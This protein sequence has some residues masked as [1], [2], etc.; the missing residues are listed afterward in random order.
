MRV[1]F[2]VCGLL[3]M[4][5]IVYGN[6]FQNGF[7]FD[8]SHTVIDNPYIR[9]LHNLS[10]FFKDARTFSTLPS[11]RT[12]RP[13][14]S[15]SLAIDYALGRG[16]NPAYFHASTFFWF[17]LQLALMFVLFLKIGDASIQDPGNHWIALFA[18]ALYGLH[19]A[20]AETMNYV[21]QRADLYS[22][23]GVIAALVC[24]I[25]A[26]RLRKFGLYLLPFVAALLSKP[27]AMVFPAI[28][29]VY[30]WLFEEEKAAP[31]LVRCVPAIAVAAGIAGFMA[32][33]TP[34][35]FNAGS[36]SAYAYRLTQPLVA[37]RY[38]R[39]FFIPDHLTADS[40][41]APVSSIVQDEAWLGF[42]FVIAVFIAAIWTSRKREW[43][44]VAFG[45]WWFL[46]AL[47]PTAVFPLAE[48]END[49]RM[50]FPFVGLTFA[51]SCAAGRWIIRRAPHGWFRAATAAAG[52]VVLS[53]CAWGTRQRNDVWHTDESLWYD[54]TVK[55]PKNGR[56]LMNY[57]LTQMEKGDY[58][59]ARDYFN[60]ALPYTPNYYLLYVNLGIVNGA[61]HDDIAAEQHFNRAIQLAPNQAEPRYFFAR[62]LDGKYR[63]P[64]A[65][66]QL[67]MAIA[68]NPDYMPA[69]YLR[70]ESSFNR[71]DWT[72]VVAEAEATLQ[73]FP[74]DTRAADYRSRALSPSRSAPLRQ[75]TAEDYLNLSLSYNR[76]RKFPESIAAAEQ[77]LKIRPNYAEAYNNM[78]AA[79]EEMHLW[80]R[81]IEQA[82]KALK[83]RPDY[84]LALNN[85]AWSEQQKR[86]ETAR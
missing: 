57:G 44:P 48:V 15:A 29:Y 32:V 7:H 86:K 54:V 40:D 84:E 77:A 83:I 19:P 49:H 50:F 13:L 64:E 68:Q 11:N 26:P 72:T 69:R 35:T 46:I 16:Y 65:M 58:L 38:F 1:A 37:L 41:F 21:I 55:S 60:R 59:R 22:T 27:P 34:P 33:M 67:E 74:S 5:S 42:V 4:V 62:W 36:Y 9:D 81:A 24:Y 82:R 39:T 43:R 75:L 8:D 45:L 6:H 78:A 76:V 51:V 14:V 17:L 53:A 23:L 52:I 30:V 79:Y 80:D 85:L 66:E 12:Y 70:M 56:G 71:G 2:L 20:I 18:A 31:A 28:L 3:A 61:L 47:I 73:R 63:W 25:R 10:L